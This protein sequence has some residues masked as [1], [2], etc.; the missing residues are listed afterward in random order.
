[1]RHGHSLWPR[2]SMLENLPTRNECVCLQKIS[3]RI[4]FFKQLFFWPHCG[5]CGILVLWPR[6][7]PGPPAV[8]V[9]SL[10]HKGNL[11]STLI[12]INL[13]LE[14]ISGLPGGLDGKEYACIVGDLDWDDP[15][16]EG[17]ATHSSIP[18]G[19]SHGQRSLVG[20]EKELYRTE[21]T[22]YIHTETINRWG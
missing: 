8:E 19:E 13:N 4:F 20:Y 16:E 7:K 11:H 18:P 10:N 17:M 22:K 14:T 1:M 15:L 5:V 3:S 2:N 21:G 12:H 9:Q 6:I